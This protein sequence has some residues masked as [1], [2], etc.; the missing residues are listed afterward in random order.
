MP[1]TNVL[2]LFLNLDGNKAVSIQNQRERMTVKMDMLGKII[3]R[4]SN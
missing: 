4:I 1:I 2:Q 3:A